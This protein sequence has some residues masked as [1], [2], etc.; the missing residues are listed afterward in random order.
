MKLRPVIKLGKKNKTSSKKVDDHVM[1]A[2]CNTI[3]IFSIYGQFGAIRKPDSGHIVC[4]L[5]IFINS[6]LLSYEN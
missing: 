2:N 1:S 5:Y 3:V 4:N 6:K